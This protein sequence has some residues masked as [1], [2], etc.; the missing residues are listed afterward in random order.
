MFLCKRKA[1]GF[2]CALKYVDPKNEKEKR[3]IKNEI[4]IMETFNH[5]NILR[6]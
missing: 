4:G 2:K 6:I 1:D 3:I 5:E